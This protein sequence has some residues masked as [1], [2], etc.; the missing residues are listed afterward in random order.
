MSE[1]WKRHEVFID[2][3]EDR[4][5]RIIPRLVTLYKSKAI[6][7][8]IADL[9]TQLGDETLSEE[10]TGEIMRQILALNEVRTRIAKKIQ[11]L[12]L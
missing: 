11:R 3:E 10:R 9:K 4:L 1:I 7:T 5:P 12:I 8:I 2:S 6:E